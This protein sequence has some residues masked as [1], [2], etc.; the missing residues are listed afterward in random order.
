MLKTAVMFVLLFA[1]VHASNMD[2]TSAC[3]HAKL[4]FETK[5]INSFEIPSDMVSGI[6][7]FNLYMY[8]WSSN[9]LFKLDRVI[10]LAVF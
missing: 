9:Y 6:R 7:I 4:A 10:R 3:L 5:G 2:R 8:M 1:V